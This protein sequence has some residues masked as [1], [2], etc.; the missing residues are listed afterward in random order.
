[1]SDAMLNQDAL[2]ESE[3]SSSSD[4]ILSSWVTGVSCLICVGVFLGLGAAE[5]ANTWDRLSQFGYLPAHAIWDGQ[6]WALITSAFVHIEIWHLAL[7]V[8]WLWVLGSRLERSIGSLL[9]LLFFAISAFVSSSFELA[10]SDSTGIGASGVV[11]AFF[12]FMWVARGKYTLFE[13]V[14]PA[15]TI[16]L[17]VGWLFVCLSLSLADIWEVGNASHFSGIFFGASIAAACTLRPY[18]VLA[19]ITAGTLLA[20]SLMFCVW[21]PWSVTW[22]SNRAYKAH[23]AGRYL[24]AIEAY[25]QLIQREPEYAW[26]FQN[27]SYAYQAVGDN[28]QAERDMETAI[29]L[30]PSLKP[31]E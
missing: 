23:V 3:P 21:C 24:D 2:T 9:F 4:S 26:A 22:L 11:Y 7:N 28:D 25:S 27:R 1:M 29:Q 10:L 31:M 6:Y 30:D 16:W 19:V 12:G 15:N 18:R 5:D 13:E 20:A 17:F 14:L 8:Y